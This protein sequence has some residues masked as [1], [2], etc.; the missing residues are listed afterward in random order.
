LAD[1]PRK[2]TADQV[3]AAIAA[4]LRG[5]APDVPPALGAE[6]ANKLKLIAAP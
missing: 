5:N 4:A 2:R 3:A 1:E 6:E